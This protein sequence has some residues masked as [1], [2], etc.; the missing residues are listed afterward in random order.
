MCDCERVRVRTHDRSDSEETQTADRAMT[1]TWHVN[2]AAPRDRWT[3]APSP[4]RHVLR[5]ALRE[6]QRVVVVEHLQRLVAAVGLRH[7]LRHAQQVGAH[8]HGR[9]A[10]G[11]R[12]QRPL[13]A[14]AAGLALRLA[15]AGV[16]DPGI[17]AP[18]P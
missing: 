3:A 6:V 17:K 7:K 18:C 9:T 15:A 10:A 4:S 11:R 5:L 2:W 12:A 8:L 13:G 16:P 1:C 14:R